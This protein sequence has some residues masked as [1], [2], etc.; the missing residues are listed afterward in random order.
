[1]TAHSLHFSFSTEIKAFEDS[2]TPICEEFGEHKE[3]HTLHTPKCAHTMH[4]CTCITTAR[5]GYVAPIQEGGSQQ[6]AT[7][8]LAS[9][10]WNTSLIFLSTWSPQCSRCTHLWAYKTH[11]MREVGYGLQ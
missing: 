1:M 5:A 3:Q 7:I 4:T 10:S 8:L 6:E 11:E 9:V 2:V